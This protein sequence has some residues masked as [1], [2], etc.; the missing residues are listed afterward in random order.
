MNV[1]IKPAQA[2]IPTAAPI[3]PAQGQAAAPAP[4]PADAP[5]PSNLLDALKQSQ[6]ALK[7]L[8][9]GVDNQTTVQAVQVQSSLQQASVL[10]ELLATLNKQAAEQREAAIAKV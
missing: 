7:T 3:S 8:L 9:T 4:G 2:A 10:P 6:D 5:A 1:N